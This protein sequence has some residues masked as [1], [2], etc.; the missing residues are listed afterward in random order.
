ML[1]VA[2][3]GLGAQG[4]SAGYVTGLGQAIDYALRR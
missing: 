3:R 4:L 1:G 2:P